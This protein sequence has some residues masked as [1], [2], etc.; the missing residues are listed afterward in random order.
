MVP[1][2]KRS[3][4]KDRRPSTINT[5]LIT[6]SKVMET[7]ILRLPKDTTHRVKTLVE[8]LQG[9]AEREADEVVAGRVEQVTAVGRVDV[10]EDA[11]DDD[12]LLLEQLLEERQAVVEGRG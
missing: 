12:A 6:M 3:L 10:E 5:L 8:V 11:G 1:D 7:L 9:W 2:S 4:N